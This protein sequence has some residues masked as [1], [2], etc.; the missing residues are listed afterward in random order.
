VNHNYK[1]RKALLSLPQIEFSYSG[2]TIAKQILETMKGYD[3]M[4]KTGYIV[5]DNASSN[6]TCCRAIE[7]TLNKQGIAFNAKKQ[8][9]RCNG[10]TINLSLDAFSLL[11]RKKLLK[12]QL[13]QQKMSSVLL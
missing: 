4:A 7:K 1:L 9:I 10:H 11:C 3:I 13:M 8:R 6:N 5:G 2:E 12:L